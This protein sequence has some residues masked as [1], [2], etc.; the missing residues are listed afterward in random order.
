MELRHMRYFLAV[1]EELN[2]TRAAARLGIGQSPLS[3]QIKD[4]ERELDVILLHR[5]PYGAE[6]TDAGSAFLEECRRT[7][8]AAE[9]AVVAAQR[10]SR[11]ELGSLR[12]GFTSSAHFNRLV[13][14]AIR[15]FTRRFPDVTLSL[16]EANTVKLVELLNSGAVD[17]I[18]SHSVIDDDGRLHSVD[19]T[20]EPLVVVLPADHELASKDQVALIELADELF[21]MK[22]RQVGPELY[23]TVLAACEKAGFR[24]KMGQETPQ[25]ATVISL[26]AANLGVSLIPSSMQHIRANGVEYR[27][28][29]GETPHVSLTLVWRRLE[30]SQAIQNFVSMVRAYKREP[31]PFHDEVRTGDSLDCA[32]T[33]ESAGTPLVVKLAL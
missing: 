13:P 3:Q 21:V 15:D 22:P 31:Q 33:L 30:R 2:F 12:I 10:A 27:P 20:Q 4:L 7:L 5:V 24:P 25:L 18:L 1:A 17:V 6:L 9:C 28:I 26:I 19:L 16:E 8:A 23:R 11:G 14:D 32:A 29:R